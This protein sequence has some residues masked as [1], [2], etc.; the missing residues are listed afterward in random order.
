[1]TQENIDYKKKY[2]EVLERAKYCLTTDM[3][4]SGY[5]AVKHIFPELKESD[6]KL[7]ELEKEVA[8]GTK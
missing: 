3:D 1:M 8:E 4:N 5:W 6:E 7:Q 2:K